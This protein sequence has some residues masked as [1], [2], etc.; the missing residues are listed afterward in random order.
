MKKLLSIIAA[1]L[2]LAMLFA[3]C[4]TKDKPGDDNKASELSQALVDEAADMIFEFNKPGENNTVAADFTLP[5]IVDYEGRDLTVEWTLEGGDGLVALEQGTGDKVNVKVDQFADK[6]TA[7]TLKGNVKGGDF[8]S[9]DIV[10]NY[11][12]GAFEI[13]NW[14]YWAEHTNDTAMNI[15]GIVVA[16]YPY[17]AAN[18]NVGV[19]LQDLD[20]EHG[21]FAYRLKCE[22]QEACDKD[23]AIGNVIVVNGTTSLYNGFREMGTGCTYVVITDADGNPQKGEVVKKSIDKYF[24]EGANLNTVLDQY[25]GMIA[26]LTGAKVTAVEWNS[27]TADT[28]VEK[29][30]GSVYVTLVKNNVKFRIYLSTSNTLT[31]DEMKAEYEKLAVGYTVDVEGP[32]AWYKEALIYPCAGAV[33]VVSSDVSASEKIANEL[34][35]LSIPN[36]VNADTVIDLANAGAEYSDVT[37][38]WTVSETPAAKI[39]GGK[40]DIKLQDAITEAVVTVTASCGGETA[41][42]EF[43]IKVM[44]ANMSMEDLV[45]EA[46]KLGAGEKLD[47]TY[48]LTGKITDI[49]TPYN[50][51]HG[52]ISVTIVVGDLADK[53]VQCYRLTG[54]GAATL[55]KGDT[56][57]VTGNIKNYNGT[58]E[59]DAGCVVSDIVKGSGGEQPTDKPTDEPAATP[60]PTQAPTDNP[61]LSS[62]DI[63]N[64]LYAVESGK[65]TTESYTLTGKIKTVNTPY[66]PSYSNVTVTIVVD[67]YDDKP[68]MCYR[69][70]GEGADTIKVD[71][72]I[73]VTGQFKNYNGTYEYAEGCTLDKIDF[74]SEDKGN[75]YTTPEEILK[76]LYALEKG[77]TLD[78]GNQY[79][80]TG[81]ITEI[82][83]AYSESYGNITVVIVVDGLDQYP[84]TCFRLKGDGADKLAVGDTVTV[85]GTLMNYVDNGKPDGLFEFTSGCVIVK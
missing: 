54:D 28:Y 66:N 53:P 1:V 48:N 45:A 57:T 31:L 74:V 14:A 2:T 78:G 12:I 34:N 69:L 67:G 32:I 76:A 43:K 35:K 52:K 26:T 70:K 75:A 5:A 36:A 58:I 72:I 10:L 18:Q 39:D 84:V 71:D 3:A 79:T 85:K 55:E 15:R 83:T 62:G 41:S 73:T 49:N 17:N 8:T 37:F 46:Y 25:Q 16:K 82:P 11:K 61:D 27:N 7:F 21:Y 56:I 80:L 19:F 63:L 9:K 64:I 20:G 40:L 51:Q 23:L 59:F 38:A 42:K 77:A 68:V 30:A 4:G 47:G 33:T 81:V 22:S 65:T 24:T 60:E 6:E 50:K 29:G 44:A 13:A